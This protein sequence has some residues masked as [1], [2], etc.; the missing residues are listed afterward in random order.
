[1]SDTKTTA[2]FYPS[3][4]LVGLSYGIWITAPQS[5][6]YAPWLC[7][8]SILTTANHALRHAALPSFFTWFTIAYINLFLIFPFLAPLIKAEIPT[9]SAIFSDY[10]FLAVTGLHLFTI[11]YEFARVRRPRRSHTGNQRLMPNRIPQA[12]WLLLGFNLLGMTLVI[13]GTGSIH[14]VASQTRDDMKLS[15]G[16][17]GNCGIYCFLCGSLLYPLLAAHLRVHR[18]QMVIW[19]PLLLVIEVFLFI[20]FRTRTHPVIHCVGLMTGWYLLPPH[21]KR[22]AVESSFRK[23]RTWSPMQFAAIATI[24]SAL[25]MSMF[26]LRTFRGAF[27]TSDSIAD[28]DLFFGD[29]IRLAFESGELGY[30]KWVCKTL[31][32]IPHRHDYIRGQSYYRIA[33]IPIPRSLWPDKPYNSQLLMAQVLFPGASRILSIP[34]GIIGDLYANFGQFGITGMVIFGYLF[35]KIDSRRDL[36]YI[37]MMSASSATVFHLVRGGFTNQVMELSVLYLTSHFV[38]LHLTHQTFTCFQSQSVAPY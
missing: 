27:E 11:G 8:A 15:I 13:A 14:A 12:L 24:I 10:T 6:P 35:G 4:L 2:M 29:S 22:T 19:I 20:A 16:L 5:T 36:T 9:S 17:L 33:F 28:I 3:I 30:A 34:V 26:V 21:M 23:K 25:V 38:V 7:L 1:M 18:S 31:E 32:T 37:L